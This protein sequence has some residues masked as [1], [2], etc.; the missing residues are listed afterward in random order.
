MTDIAQEVADIQ[1]RI[2]QLEAL[3]E[4][5]LK[6][7]MKDLKKALMDN[8]DACSLMLPEDIGKMVEALRRMTG[9]ALVEEKTKT[10]TKKQTAAEIKE[11]LGQPLA[12]DF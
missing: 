9:Q 1:N 7:A 4:D 10:K 5:D 6:P 12:D 2:T 11:M 3:S 8:P